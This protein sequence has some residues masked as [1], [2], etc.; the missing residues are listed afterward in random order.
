S[1]ARVV[2]AGLARPRDAKPVQESVEVERESF[3][4]EATAGMKAIV[5]EPHLRLLSGLYGAQTLGAGA[6]SVFTVAVA[7]DL[8]DLEASGVGWLS[9]ASGLGGLLG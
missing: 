4:R 1:G 8:L 2:G 7:L 5:G 6:G 3:V 9:A